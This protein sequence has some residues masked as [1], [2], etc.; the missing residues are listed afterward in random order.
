MYLPLLLFLQWH[1]EVVRRGSS[2]ANT[3]T[4]IQPVYRARQYPYN[5][6]DRG[7]M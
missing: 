2:I 4:V 3:W 5:R 1:I 6:Q 7:K